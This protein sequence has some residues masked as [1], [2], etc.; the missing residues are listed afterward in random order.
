MYPHGDD[1]TDSLIN[2]IGFIINASPN[3]KY[4]I[5][6]GLRSKFKKEEQCWKS[7]NNIID[8]GWTSALDSLSLSYYDIL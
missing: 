8:F 7:R 2:E 1:A 3:R 6:V 4:D 5:I